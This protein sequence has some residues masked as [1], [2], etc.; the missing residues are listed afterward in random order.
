[1]P[2]QWALK[3]AVTLRVASMS[4]SGHAPLQEASRRE[5]FHK[6]WERLRAL[7]LTPPE[8]PATPPDVV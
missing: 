8:A 7:G 3:F 4:Y 2:Y 6:I 5:R 1:M